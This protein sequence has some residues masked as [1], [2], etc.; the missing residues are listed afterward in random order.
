MS[1]KTRDII[2]AK[3]GRLDEYLKYLRELQTYDREAF[4]SDYRI[5]GLAERYLQVSIEAMIDVARLTLIIMN[6][7]KPENN[8]EVFEL[9]CKNKVISKQLYER[10]RNISGFRNILVHDYMKI[11]RGLVYESLHSGLKD[12][13][14]FRKAI[15]RNL[16]KR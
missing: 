15:I 10:T 2:L 6:L 5:H 13:V 8:Y 4:I 7:E 9:L 14:D 3:L 11:D 16:E 12:F 1:P